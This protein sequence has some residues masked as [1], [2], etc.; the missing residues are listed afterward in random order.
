MSWPWSIPQVPTYTGGST[1]VPVYCCGCRE[2][3]VLPGQFMIVGN[4]SY[5]VGCE[6]RP[7]PAPSAPQP[8]KR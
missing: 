1:A 3:I 7:A 8:T 4:L 6:K 5:H 2:Q